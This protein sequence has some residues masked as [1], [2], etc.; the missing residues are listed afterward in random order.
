MA[1][2]PVAQWL[3]PAAHNGLV[4]GSSPARPTIFIL[5]N[6]NMLCHFSSELREE[7]LSETQQSTQRKGPKSSKCNGPGAARVLACRAACPCGP[8]RSRPDLPREWGSRS[9]CLQCRCDHCRRS[10]RTDTN[11]RVLHLHQDRAKRGLVPWRWRGRSVLHDQL[12]E[13]GCGRCRACCMPP[14]INKAGANIRAPGHFGHHGARLFDR[15]QNSRALFTTP[16]AAP[17]AARD[18][19]HPA[20][21]VQLASLIRTI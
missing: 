5:N 20:H 21:A 12:G 14:L 11:P 3:E 1:A 8:S 17:L 6:F 18:Q 15:S 2:G 16:T 13:A 4:A 19:S 9:Q 7:P 10:V